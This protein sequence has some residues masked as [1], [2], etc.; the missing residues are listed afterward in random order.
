MDKE[1][2]AAQRIIKILTDLNPGQRSN[3][4]GYVARRAEQEYYSGGKDNA[5]ETIAGNTI[6]GSVAAP[7]Y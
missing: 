1:L 3:V 5:V 4:I 2:K 7:G 6:A